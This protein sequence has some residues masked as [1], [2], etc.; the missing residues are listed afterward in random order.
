MKPF[1]ELSDEQKS[2]L[3][4]KAAGWQ[5]CPP[6]DWLDATGSNYLF[7]IKNRHEFDLYSPYLMDAAWRILNWWQW[8]K[9]EEGGGL[10]EKLFFAAFGDFEIWMSLP[11]ELARRKWLDKI[12]KM[13]IDA[14][15]VNE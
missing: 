7:S 9:S 8:R 2:W 14:G 13:C 1:E 6:F 5:Y 15:L 11:P 10:P 12:L 4:A 3:L